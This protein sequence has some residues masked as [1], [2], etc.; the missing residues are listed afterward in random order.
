MVS[1]GDLV[2]LELHFLG[3]ENRLLHSHIESLLA[4]RCFTKQTNPYSNIFLTWYCAK[5]HSCTHSVRFGICEPTVCKAKT[6]AFAEHV[7]GDNL[8]TRLH[9]LGVLVFIGFSRNPAV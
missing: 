8:S 1:I 9:S 7:G 2:K 5:I 3:I 6:R 4:N